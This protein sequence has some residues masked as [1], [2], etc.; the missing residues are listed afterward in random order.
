MGVHWRLEQAALVSTTGVEV[1]PQHRRNAL[2]ERLSSEPQPPVFVI[3]PRPLRRA[4]PRWIAT[5]QSL[6]L[7]QWGG[8]RPSFGSKYFLFN[9][10]SAWPFI[11]CHR[12]AAAPNP[13]NGEEK[14]YP[15]T[16]AHGLQAAAGGSTQRELDPCSKDDHQ[17]PLPRASVC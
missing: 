5:S 3:H 1:C 9:A 7:S 16:A 2:S 13:G 17:T 12:L 8:L 6:S 14:G 4:V 10:T 15:W 11:Q